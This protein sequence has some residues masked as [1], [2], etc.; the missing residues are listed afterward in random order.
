MVRLDINERHISNHSVLGKAR[1]GDDASEMKP[2]RVRDVGSE[3]AV[4]RL[5]FE[6]RLR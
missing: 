1:R 5:N 4:E 6:T 2:R 3:H